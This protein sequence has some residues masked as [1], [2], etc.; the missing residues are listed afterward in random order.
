MSELSD[1]AK[2]VNMSQ[3]SSTLHDSLVMALQKKVEN[4]ST[5]MPSDFVRCLEAV[6][7]SSLPDEQKKKLSDAVVTKA[8]AATQE[9]GTRR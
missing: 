4:T 8:A 5:L 1:V 9:Q 3:A 2:L 6:E 7:K